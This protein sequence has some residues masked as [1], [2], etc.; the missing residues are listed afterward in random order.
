[1]HV[2]AQ[3]TEARALLERLR[4]DLERVRERHQLILSHAAMDD[5]DDTPAASTSRASAT[6]P[7]SSLLT[8]NTRQL[9]EELERWGTE[10]RRNAQRARDILKGASRVESS[11]QLQRQHITRLLVYERRAQM[12]IDHLLGTW[13]STVHS[14][15]EIGQCF[16]KGLCL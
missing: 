3:E 16:Y 6:A 5:S 2:R 14:L 9:R 15:F 1:M 13:A 4:A 8:G 10:F 11:R 12:R 7:T